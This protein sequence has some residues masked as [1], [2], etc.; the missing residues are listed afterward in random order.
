MMGRPSDK[1]MG[2]RCGRANQ[3]T[4]VP[5][6]LFPSALSAWDTVTGTYPQDHL[7]SIPELERAA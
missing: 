6:A 4:P 5:Q 1:G 2:V 7:V 3:S